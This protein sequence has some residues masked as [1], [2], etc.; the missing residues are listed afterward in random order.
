M[1]ATFDAAVQAVLLRS[2][3]LSSDSISYAAAA[4]VVNSVHKTLLGERDWPFLQKNG[5]INTVPPVTTGTVSGSFLSPTVQGLN[6][7][8][9]DTMVG[10]YIVIGNFYD[11][12]EIIAVDVANQVLT[13]NPPVTMETYVQPG[14]VYSS[15]PF[16]IFNL[17]YAFPSD[18]RMP[19]ETDNFLTNAPMKFVGEREF[20]RLS[21]YPFFDYPVRWSIVMRSGLPQLALYP[22]PIGAYQIV[23]TYFPLITDLVNTADPILI[24]DNYREIL[25]QSALA[26]VLAN[27]LNN[28]NWQRSFKVAQDLK[29]AMYSDY[30]PWDDA[31]Q[32]VPKSYRLRA[33]ATSDDFAIM[34]TVWGYN[35]GI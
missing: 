22:F 26:E 24:P 7:T 5:A 3:Q 31:P 35:G 11:Y 32:M 19:G 14:Q 34:R 6:T 9:V 15:M 25:I 2:N 16:Y 12:Y 17:S 1:Y 29:A 20:R 18:F 33:G 23:F 10:Q 30:K 27:Q 21:T 28:P 8:F 4:D 13:V